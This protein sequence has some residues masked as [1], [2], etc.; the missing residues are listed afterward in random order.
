MFINLITGKSRIKILTASVT[1]VFIS[2]NEYVLKI[3]DIVYSI[4]WTKGAK[5]GVDIFNLGEYYEKVKSSGELKKDDIAFFS[6]IDEIMKTTDKILLSAI[7]DT[8]MAD[9]L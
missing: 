7:T 9:E 5:S 6:T 2:K 1:I 4:Q 3:K 8:Y